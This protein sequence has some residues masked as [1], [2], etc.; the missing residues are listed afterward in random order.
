M[1]V[2]KLLVVGAEAGIS[3]DAISC[4]SLG[5]NMSQQFAVQELHESLEISRDHL[6]P[7]LLR[8]IDITDER[9]TFQP[10]NLSGL[11]IGSKQCTATVR[12]KHGDSP[13]GHASHLCWLSAAQPL[14]HILGLIDKEPWTDIRQGDLRHV[15]I[16]LDQI[17]R[18]RVTQ[19]RSERIA[20]T[21]ISGS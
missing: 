5:G 10:N 1:G 21:A 7:G 12:A 3:S 8:L 14:N 2:D 18:T 17:P 19:D 20:T 13:I 15:Q 9:S 6:Y 4:L 11:T 16:E